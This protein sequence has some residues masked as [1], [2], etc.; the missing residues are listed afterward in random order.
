MTI[1]ANPLVIP[2]VEKT[3]TMLMMT[4]LEIIIDHLF[5]RGHDDPDNY[6][7]WAPTEQL[8]AYCKSL[9]GPTPRHEVVSPNGCV[10]RD[11]QRSPNTPTR[12]RAGKGDCGIVIRGVRACFRPEKDKASRFVAATGGK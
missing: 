2:D 5:N 3:Q 6:Y 10:Y 12:G 9:R 11:R 4:L 7:M 1:S 8:R